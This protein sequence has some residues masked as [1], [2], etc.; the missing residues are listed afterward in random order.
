METAATAGDQRII[1]VPDTYYGA[2][3][4]QYILYIPKNARILVP[5][6]DKYLVYTLPRYV[7][8]LLVCTVVL[9]GGTTVVPVGLGDRTTKGRL[10]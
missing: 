2:N 9:P 6:H 5:G 3:N 4:S 10:Q 7:S 8:M 1:I